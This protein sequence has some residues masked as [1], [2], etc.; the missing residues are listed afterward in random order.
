MADDWA[1]LIATCLAE[2][3]KPGETDAIKRST[4]RALKHYRPYRFF[5][6][7]K[8]G[9]ITLTAGTDEYTGPTDLLQP[10]HLLYTTAAGTPRNEIALV[11]T[12]E[13]RDMQVYGIVSGEPEYAAYHH[14]KFVF[15][16]VPSVTNDTVAVWY[17]VDAT[18]DAGGAVITV[19]SATTVTNPYF[20]RAEEL[21]RTRVL[22]D[23]FLT[24]VHDEEKAT[25]YKL[26]N[27]EAER[28]LRSETSNLKMKGRSVRGYF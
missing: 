3:H 28:S 18:R 1:E 6:S 11:S 16:P 20:V 9:S 15:Y 26:L 4:V 21:L 23:F 10:D 17:Q 13:I 2:S 19:A 27:A 24:R 14:Q 22:Y 7:E 25:M 5:F 12:D 8:K